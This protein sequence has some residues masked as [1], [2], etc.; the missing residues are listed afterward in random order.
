MKFKFENRPMLLLFVTPILFSACGQNNFKMEKQRTQDLTYNH[1]LDSNDNFSPDDEW[2]VYDTRTEKGG[3]GGNGK[4]EKIHL[5][6]GEKVV[7]YELEQNQAYGP[8]VGAV[9]YSHANNEV[10]FIHGLMNCSE[11]K[12]YEQWRRSGVIIKDDKPGEPIFMDARDI[13]PPFTVGALRGGTHRHEYS[14]DGQWIGFT[15]NDAIMKKLEDSTGVTHNLRTIGVSKNHQPV[16]VAESPDGENFSGEWFSAL[17][18]KVVPDPNPGSDEISKAA[19]DSWV[20][21]SGYLKSDGGT[22]RARAFI[23]TTTNKEG[24][25]V[26]EVYI[27][28]IPED[29]TIPGDGALEGT[30]TTMPAPPKGTQQRR[31]TYTTNNKYP[32]CEGIVRSSYG[33]SM[34]AYL[35]QDDHNIKQ[36]FTISPW[37]GEPV[38]RTFHDSDV[39]GGVRWHPKEHRLIYV[40]QNSL[41]GLNIEGGKNTVLTKPTQNPPKNPVWSHDGRKIAYNRMVSNNGETPTMQIFVLEL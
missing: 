5:K 40:W 41:M 37:G 28:D 18:V 15:Y 20:G 39:Q 2:L 13:S 17:V 26:D 21:H 9:S 16:T 4:I 33:G 10:V 22:Q 36:I 30:E 14:G 23:G 6:T 32:G 38:Q 34:L 35:A 29:I 11:E 27:V 24:E 1:D 31:L 3:I 12:P 7:L 8:G 19:G 25:Q